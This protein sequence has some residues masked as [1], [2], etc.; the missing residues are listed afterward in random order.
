RLVADGYAQR[1]EDPLDRRVTWLT[2]T[3]R[4]RQAIEQIM[5]SRQEAVAAVFGTI[6]ADA[7]AARQVAD[8]LALLAEAAEQLSPPPAHPDAVERLAAPAGERA[9]PSS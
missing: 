2:P 8:G 5:T 4:G 3:A 6:P 9:L 1:E 7:L